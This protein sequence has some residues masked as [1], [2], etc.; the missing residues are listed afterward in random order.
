MGQGRLVDTGQRRACSLL[1]CQWSLPLRCQS[2]L[3]Q[4]YLR[5]RVHHCI[6]LFLE[7]S[8]LCIQIGPRPSDSLPLIVN[9]LDF[10]I[11]FWIFKRPVILVAPKK[12]STITLPTLIPHRA[13]PVYNSVHPSDAPLP[14]FLVH[15]TFPCPPTILEPPVPNKSLRRSNME[16]DS[17]LNDHWIPPMEQLP[18]PTM[19]QQMPISTLLH[20]QYLKS[21]W[22]VITLADLW[23]SYLQCNANRVWQ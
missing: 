12:P 20:G 1:R 8:V 14:A 22:F 3:V 9:V 21:A 16:T 7:I 19:P 2:R 15:Q 10:R 4:V 17:Y 5:A 18:A 13:I 11:H 23:H 6:L